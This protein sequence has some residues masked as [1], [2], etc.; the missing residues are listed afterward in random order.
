MKW[1][2]SKQ[3]K[4]TKQKPC[5]ADDDE[6]VFV[7]DDKE[8]TGKV[9]SSNGTDCYIRNPNTSNDQVFNKLGIVRPLKY[10]ESIQGYEYNGCWPYSRTLKDLTKVVKAVLK[11]CEKHNAKLEEEK[12]AEPRKG[13][14]ENPWTN[15]EQTR[16][17]MSQI[18]DYYRYTSG[19][20]VQRIK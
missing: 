18:G 11:E 6:I 17:F 19:I 20:V 16:P 3:F 10:A 13:S 14:L 7:V 12:D 15:I 9:E 5:L 4:S 8:I 1:T 2:N